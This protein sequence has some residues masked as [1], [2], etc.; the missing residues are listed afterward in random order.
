M[1][2]RLISV[3]LCSLLVAACGGGSSGSAPAAAAPG[4][5]GANPT[6]AT[7]VTGTPPAPKPDASAAPLPGAPAPPGG[8]SGPTPTPAASSVAGLAPAPAQTPAA[9]PGAAPA[10]PSALPA[11][12]FF[13]E[14]LLATWADG[15][16][17]NATSFSAKDVAAP[18]G[19][20]SASVSFTNAY[21]AFAMANWNTPVDT[22]GYNAVALSVRGSSSARYLE[23]FVEGAFGGNH[24]AAALPDVKAGEWQDV[25]IYLAD[26]GLPSAIH[27]IGLANDSR[28]L[29]YTNASTAE[30]N[31]TFYV[32]RLRLVS[33]APPPVPAAQAGPALTVNLNGSKRSISPDIY[34]LNFDNQTAFA[35]EIKLPVNRWGGDA[36]PRF[37]Y[38]TNHS[39]PGFNW[40][41]AN[42]LEGL[43]PGN[44]IAFNQQASSQ[45]MLTLPL[46]GWAAKD[47]TSCGYSVAR[48]GA[49]PNVAPDR[50]DCGT[51]LTASN[52]LITRNT[53]TDTS[54]ATTAEFYRP[55]IQQLVATYG[56]ADQG[57][58]RFYNLDNEPGIW[59]STH[60]D[61]VKSGVTHTDLL[62]RSI[63]AATMLKS[64]DPSAKTLGPAEDGWTRYIVSG[65]DSELSNWGAR[66]DG[67][68]AVEWYLKEMR[69]QES[70][71]GKRLL[72]YFDLHY[73]PQAS[74]IYGAA[75]SKAQQALRLRTVRSLWDPSYVD[76]S[77]IS[78]TDIKSVKL[79]PRMRQWIDTHYPGTKLAI[80]EYNFGALNH[81]NGALAQ[82]DVLGVFGREGVD[83]ATLWGPPES[84]AGD[85]GLF[86]NKPG[87]FAM[88]MFRNY[89]GAG[90]QFGD[91]SVQ[92]ASADQDRLSVYASTDSKDGAL[93]VIVINKTD[94]PL[95]S[96]VALQGYTAASAV[97]FYRYGA[98]NLSSIEVGD[99]TATASGVAATFAPNSITL[100]RVVRP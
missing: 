62:A 46:M 92:A 57:G 79:I 88:R 60:R 10:A 30:F 84:Y 37:N 97:K 2:K 64:V 54:V 42:R 11:V 63:A 13:D 77:W 55:W 78:S 21:G 43:T 5:G 39:N 28:R 99:L 25:V 50:S 71:T 68:W 89:D 69:A 93:K 73:Y 90:G 61:V 12:V 49:Q 8:T 38:T 96:T 24:A 76:E 75:G 32:D 65:R 45:T 31:S 27:R 53:P 98:A 83:L 52:A 7:P 44:F 91:V 72:D 1:Q 23:L 17:N 95:A 41:F 86:A 81:I 22:A 47:A 87:G 9:F 26:L 3:A 18:S 59:N 20:V 67:L 100:M 40:Y 82:A 74:G 58:V 33:V 4:A 19:A 15:G 16:W 94:T 56:R 6:P 35:A 48:Y 80:T 36:T 66:Y 29:D 34:G 85:T 70:R 51:G 14:A